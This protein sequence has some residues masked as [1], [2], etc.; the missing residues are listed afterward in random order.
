MIR[1]S[2]CAERKHFVWRRIIDIMGQGGWWVHQAVEHFSNFR[3]WLGLLFF[4]MTIH[5]PVVFTMTQRNDWCLL[6]LL[7]YYT[8]TSENFNLNLNIVIRSKVH[9]IFFLFRTHMSS[10]LKTLEASLKN[11]MVSFSM[12]FWCFQDGISSNELISDGLFGVR[13]LNLH[14]RKLRWN[15]KITRLKRKIIWT[16]SP[17]DSILIFRGVFHVSGFT[18]MMVEIYW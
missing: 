8:D 17:W 10:N 3:R 18:L 13:I 14:L 2:H 12:M 11:K 6:C 15:L 5:H 4:D 16:K 1:C 7:I 9:A